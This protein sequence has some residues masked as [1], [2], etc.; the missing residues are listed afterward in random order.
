[1]EE[2]GKKNIIVDTL[3]E[4]NLHP[5]KFASSKNIYNKNNGLNLIQFN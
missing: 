2:Y 5:E 3:F 1:M 4:S